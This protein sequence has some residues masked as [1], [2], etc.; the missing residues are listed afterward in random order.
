[1]FGV[2][3]TALALAG[4][5]LAWRRRSARLLALAWL[6]AAALAVGPVLRIGGHA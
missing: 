4:L 5:A 1:M 6:G 3:L 2:V